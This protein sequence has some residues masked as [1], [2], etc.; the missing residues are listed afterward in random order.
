MKC[1]ALAAFLGTVSLCAA[2]GLN[3]PQFRGPNGS[4][5]MDDA[6][7]PVKF[8]RQENVAWEV[9]VPSAPSSPIVW[10]DRV[11]LT[12]VEGTKLQTRAYDANDGKLVW[13][14]SIEAAKFED[15]LPGEGSYAASTPVSDG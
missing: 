6:N 8:G 12:A 14:S 13:K 15:V 4:G 7:P 2:A 11:F 9:D 10:G 5:V 3:W 1:L